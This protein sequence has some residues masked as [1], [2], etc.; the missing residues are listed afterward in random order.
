MRV[1]NDEDTPLVIICALRYCFGRRTYMPSTIVEWIKNH[2]QEIPPTYQAI[3]KSDVCEYV[4]SGRSL[5]D[6]CDADTWI[7]FVKWFDEGR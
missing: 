1:K 2:W 5:G 4:S 3:I 7:G 6:Q